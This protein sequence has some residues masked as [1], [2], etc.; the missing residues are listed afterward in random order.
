MKI[1][2]KKGF[3]LVELLGAIV[4]LV[5][6][7]LIAIPVVT[8]AVKK[9]NEKLYNIQIKNVKIS[10]K[11]WADDNSNK[12]PQIGNYLTITLKDLQKLGY[13][14][15][16]LKNPKTGEKMEDFNITICNVGNYYGYEKESSFAEDSWET[17]IANVKAG[18][19]C[20]YKVGEEKEVTL[21]GFGTYTVRIA[22]ISTP[23]ECNTEGFSQTACGFVIEFEDI[24]TTYNMNSANINEDGWKKSEMR[25]YVNSVIYNALP[26]EIKEN[27]TNTYVVSGHG[28]A[29]GETNF[30]T[31]DKLYL[32]S[33]KEVWGEGIDYDTAQTE[34]RQLD[35]YKTI[36]VTTSNYSGA[37]K[38][39]NGSSGYWWLR[40]AYPNLTVRFFHVNNNGARN[41]N[42]AS[43]TYG[44]SVAFRIG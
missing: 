38:K 24:I 12:L 39:Y 34:T 41:S 43:Y 29:S 27:I 23:K 36:G 22:N 6:L 20:A 13:V 16:T 44:V 25:E 3:T 32:L 14:D 31:T 30:R 7:S 17:I 9:N 4:I 35:Y 18:R 15:K 8:N 21:E 26:K 11:V 2:N 1:K 40:S 10:A 19:L 5:L 28:S 37:I 33:T 42:G